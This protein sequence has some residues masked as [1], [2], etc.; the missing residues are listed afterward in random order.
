MTKDRNLDFLIN[1]AELIYNALQLSKTELLTKYDFLKH[2]LPDKLSVFNTYELAE[3]AP[4]LTPSEREIMITKKYGAVLVIQIGH[5]IG[6]SD[7]HALRAH[8]YDDWMLN[9]DLI[10]WDHINQSPIE[11]SSMGIRVDHESLIN[12]AA[13]AGANLD[14]DFHQ[15]VIKQELPPSIGGGIGRSRVNL[16]LLEQDHIIKVK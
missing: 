16:F 10:V 11:L 6:D 3:M 12:Q 4:T 7:P 13:I 2:P 1:Q 15:K 14:T 8:D 9:G 5:K